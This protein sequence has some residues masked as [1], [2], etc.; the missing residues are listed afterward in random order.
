MLIFENKIK[1]KYYKKMSI[2]NILNNDEYKIIFLK[3]ILLGINY[4]QS[5]NINYYKENIQN[6]ILKINEKK[7]TIIIK[8]TNSACDKFENIIASLEKQKNYTLNMINNLSNNNYGY[9]YSRINLLRSN[10][11][12][13]NK[14]IIKN[15][16]LLKKNKDLIEKDRDNKSPEKLFLCGLGEIRSIIRENDS[17]KSN[18]DILPKKNEN[19][20]GELEKTLGSLSN[21]LIK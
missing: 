8:N 10:L 19:F 9:N 12:L 18:K 14:E 16:L 3:A 7:N 11:T 2:E 20:V 21:L 5:N 6:E 1:N 17:T 4:G 13:I 15:K